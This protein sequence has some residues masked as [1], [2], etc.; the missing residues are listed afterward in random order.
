NRES[1]RSAARGDFAP[2]PSCANLAV[3]STAIDPRFAIASRASDLALWQAN[4]VRDRLAALCPDCA[5]EVVAMT[6]RGDQILDRSLAKIGGKGLFV[7][8]LENALA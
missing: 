5:V 2:P 3:M 4:H 6:T 8:E 7:K 1:V